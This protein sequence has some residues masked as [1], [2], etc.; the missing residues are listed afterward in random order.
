MFPF[1]PFPM[2]P[3]NY[4]P[5]TWQYPM[6]FQPQMH[7]AGH[8][9]P[10]VVETNAAPMTSF[11]FSATSAMPTSMEPR[12]EGAVHRTDRSRS[13]QASGSRRPVSP[14]RPPRPPGFWGHPAELALRQG[15]TRPSSS[16]VPRNDAMS[17]GAPTTVGSRFETVSGRR[18]L[19]QEERKSLSILNA[20]NEQVIQCIQFLKHIGQDKLPETSC[21][22]LA[23]H[24]VAAKMPYEQ[25]ITSMVMATYH[26]HDIFR[27][28]VSGMEGP[29]TS[30]P[31]VGTH[32]FFWSHGTT[33]QGFVGCMKLK[34]MLKSL[35]DENYK[36]YGF[37]CSATNF[38]DDIK[39]VHRC[40]I[41]RWQSSRN[42]CNLLICG[43]AQSQC[44]HAIVSSGGT[45]AEQRACK[46]NGVCHN[47]KEKRWT[48]KPKLATITE[49][50]ICH[51]SDPPTSDS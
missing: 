19:V 45:Y 2:M 31:G 46:H 28:T 43:T 11:S 18:N 30:V 47:K 8:V 48:V 24:L 3:P 15:P 16:V 42:D 17:M 21:V 20:T 23:K 13:R 34:R 12:M 39:E 27:F 25:A 22:N 7:S 33:S 32:R 50:V 37:F 49:I 40:I 9:Q 4:W 26:Q 38:P 51:E 44:P 1:S 6:H 41:S 14:A 5:M 35:P 10:L 29:S 36:T